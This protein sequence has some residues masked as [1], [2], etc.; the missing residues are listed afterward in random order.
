MIRHAGEQPVEE[1]D[2]RLLWFIQGNGKDEWW[3]DLFTTLLKWTRKVFSPAVAERRAQFGCMKRALLLLDGLGS[4]HTDEFLQTC[5]GQ[6]IDVLFLVPNSSDQTPPL[7]V[8]TFALMKRNFSR[9]RFSRLENPQSNQLVRILGAWSLKR[10]KCPTSQ[11]RSLPED[12]AGPIR[13]TLEVW[14]ILP[15]GATR[16]GPMCPMRAQTGRGRQQ[17]NVT[18]RRAEEGTSPYW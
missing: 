18:A 11:H 13:E 12:W 8:L 15:E 4:H 10:V 17:G 9:S 14:K 6:D 1:H 3:R 16:G 7:D 5:A 2:A